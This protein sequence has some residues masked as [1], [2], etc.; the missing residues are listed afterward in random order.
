MSVGLGCRAAAPRAHEADT[1]NATSGRSDPASARP[2]AAIIRASAAPPY[3]WLAG[4]WSNA[5]W[6]TT[7]TSIAAAAKRSRSL[8]SPSSGS[9]PRPKILRAPASERA[10]DG[11]DARRQEG[12]DRRP[13]QVQRGNVLLE[14]AVLVGDVGAEQRLEGRVSL[15]G[16]ARLLRVLGELDLLVFGAASRRGVETAAGDRR[17][18]RETEDARRIHPLS[19]VGVF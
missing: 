15:G 17:G 7:S 19:D 3:F 6:I 9:P 8:T 18:D 14:S 12:R 11:Q 16:Q 4:L 13:V 2:S 10:E 1:G 5:A